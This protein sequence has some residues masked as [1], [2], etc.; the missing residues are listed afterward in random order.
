MDAN[1]EEKKRPN[2]RAKA[3]PLSA[4]LFGWML[5]IFWKG[6]KKDLEMDD[7]F[8][9]LDEHKSDYLGNKFEKRWNEELSRASKEGRQPSLLRV[10]MR[11][12]GL[13][14]M[15]YGLILAFL[16]IGLRMNQPIFLGLMVRSFVQRGSN[17][18]QTHQ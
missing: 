12:F 17:Y 4:L 6:Y 11:C 8:V 14:L 10:I 3:N 5:K 7:L 15:G 16:E 1:K 13:S 9:P 2:P 18:T